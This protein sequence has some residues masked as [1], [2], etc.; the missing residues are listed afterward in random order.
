VLSYLADLET[1]LS[2]LES[3]L[4]DLEALK[5]RGE[6]R[7]EEARAWAK[8]ALEMLDCIRADVCSHLPEF[9]F[10]DMSVENFV[11]SHLPDF[12]DVPAL[13]GMRS[14]FPDMPNVRSRLPDIPDVR[15]K[16]P[17]V[18]ARLPDM[19]DVR[20][21]LPD[22]PDVRSRLPDFDLSDMRSKFDDVRTRFYDLDFHH[23]LS[24]IPTLS[25]HL[26][27]LHYHLSSVELSSGIELPSLAPSSML[28][29]LLDAL[30]SSDM[31]SELLNAPGNV[32]EGEAFLT[33]QVAKAVKSSFQGSRLIAYVDLPKE[34]R[35][36]PFVAHGYR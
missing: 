21:R 7:I 5:A 26:Q 35:S 14:H 4:S 33:A 30:V 24:Y 29:D 36:N 17:D 6:L 32:M 10:P 8:T 11:K 9:N 15:S 28:S 19:P 2:Q 13:H 3:P 31:F 1:R 34:W 22:M 25:D 27:S 12:T 20:S 18:R 23:P 16:L